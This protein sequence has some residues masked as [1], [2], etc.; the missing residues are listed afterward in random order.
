MDVYGLI[1][2]FMILFMRYRLHKSRLSQG[3]NGP[4]VFLHLFVS[5]F[6]IQPQTMTYFIVSIVKFS[7]SIEKGRFTGHNLFSTTC[8]HLGEKRRTIAHC[9][10]VKGRF[11]RYDFVARDKFTTGLRHVLGP[12]TRERHFHLQN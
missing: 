3:N 8:S 10:F 2:Y 11:T 9:L 1:T 6:L 4:L 5:H 12:F 7:H